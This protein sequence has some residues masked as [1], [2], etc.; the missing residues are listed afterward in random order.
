MELIN[1]IGPK[2][3]DVTGGGP[4]SR[5]SVP[6]ETAIKGLLIRIQSASAGIKNS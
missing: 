6:F 2:K 1:P 3:I 4:V 5:E